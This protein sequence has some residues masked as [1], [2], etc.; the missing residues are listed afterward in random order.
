MFNDIYQSLKQSLSTV[1]GAEWRDELGEN[2]FRAGD[3]RAL[4]VDMSGTSFSA[5]GDISARSTR[6]KA[7]RVIH[8]T[9]SMDVFVVFTAKRQADLFKLADSIVDVIRAWVKDY[10]KPRGIYVELGEASETEASADKTRGKVKQF[11]LSV[12]YDSDNFFKPVNA[13]PGQEA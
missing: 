4:A 12:S 13:Q 3:D 7:L 2:V 5:I 9:T 6:Q 10:A 1:D 11:V 8:G